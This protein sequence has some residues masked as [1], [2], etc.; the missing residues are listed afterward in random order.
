MT[1]KQ[2]S[3]EFGEKEVCE[4]LPCPNC[5][6][7]LFQ[8]AKNNPLYDIACSKCLFRAQV[9]TPGKDFSGKFI[10]GAGWNI[11]DKAMK[12]GIIIPPVILNLKSEIRFYPYIPKTALMKRTAKI[13][14]KGK[15][16]PRIHLM[17]DY[18]LSDLK[19][20]VLLKKA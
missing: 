18:N 15:E 16:E 2:D 20:F 12:A 7:R 14:Q 10:R 13:K 17:F 11:L 9:K 1:L 8:L 19:Y 6:G 3:G 4:L 5:G